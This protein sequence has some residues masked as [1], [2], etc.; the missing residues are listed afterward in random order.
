M[1][2]AA[3]NTTAPLSFD[4]DTFAAVDIGSNSFHLIVAR[5]A[6]GTLQ[7]MVMDKQLV[8]LAEGLDQDRILSQ[9]AIDRG[10]TILRSFARVLKDMDPAR[11]RVVATFTLRRARN[12][13]DFLHA[14]REVFPFPIE[15]ISGDEEAR[16]IY[17]GIAHTTHFEGKRLVIDIGGG[18]TEFAIGENFELL[19]LSSQ[20]MGCIS[21]SKRFF[22]DGSISRERFKKAETTARQRLEV[23]DQRFERT[24]WDAAIGSSGT[25]KAILAYGMHHGLL[26]ESSIS[27]EQL[28]AIRRSLIKVGH[29][30]AIE[31][32]DDGRKPVIAGGLSILIA[33]FKEFGI[34]RL[35][36]SDAALREGVLYE[37]TERMQHHDIRERTVTSLVSR[38]HIDLDQ[39]Q[40]VYNTAKL[41]YSAFVSQLKGTQTEPLRHVLYWACMLHE[42]GLHINRRGL[43]RHSRYIVENLEL[44]GFSD[45][46]QKLLGLLVGSWRKGFKRKDIPDFSLF[47]R[48]A[49]FSLVVI[50]R[51]AT[52]M[53]LRRLD[54]FL[55]ELHLQAGKA[56]LNLGFSSEWLEAHPLTLADLQSEAALL[57]GNSF[58]LELS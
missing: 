44:P 5:L 27:L 31:G 16:L 49:V 15:V 19:Q 47:D 33:A 38:F 13:N 6:N 1:I 37:M 25:A 11:V 52:L 58:K 20:P 56:R 29:C 39:A 21:Y 10:I 48:E 4:K 34:E 23:I 8:R 12:R 53:N 51:L 14:A 40:R 43:Q 57:G 42:I 35:G 36:V 46:E 45:E 41:L 9:D 22:E 55:P 24:G 50:L 7:P 2:E 17:Q 3:D 28:K 54:G 30:D 32:I 26:S 18:S